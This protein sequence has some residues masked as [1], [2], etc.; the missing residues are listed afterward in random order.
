MSKYSYTLP[1]LIEQS[2]QKFPNK[3][4]FRFMGASISYS[5]LE[6]Q[7]HQLAHLLI[8]LG[9]K[10][11]DRVGI[12][13]A[14][15]LE[16]AIAMYGIMSAGAIYVPINPAQPVARTHFLLKDCGIKYLVTNAGQKRSL[17]SVV[18][19][20]V[21]LESVIGTNVALPTCTIEWSDLAQMPS[22]RPDLSILETDIAYMLYTSGSTGTPKG[23]MHTHYS[24]L[25]YARLSV[26][27]YDLCADDILGNHA[28]IYFD[29][30]T[31]GYFAA[32]LVGATTVIASEAHIKMPAS[33]SQLIEKEKI[34][35][36]Y[37]VPLALIQMLQR[38]ALEQRDMAQLRWVIFAGEL[39][40]TK[41]LRQLMLQWPKARFSNAY[42]PTETNVCTYYHLPAI[43]ENDLPISIG[44]AWNNTEILILGK[45]NRPLRTGQVGE[46][47]VRSATLM[48]GYASRPDLNKKAF[49]FTKNQFGIQKKFYR[50]GDLVKEESDGNLTFLGRKDRQIKTRG[51]RVELDEITTF[52]LQ[53]PN[54]EEAAVY[55]VLNEEEQTLIE[56]AVIL[57]SHEDIKEQDLIQHL[58][59]QLPSYALPHKINI[60]QQFPRTATGK[61]D[62]KLL[63]NN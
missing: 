42:G 20:E 47:L 24:G 37:S 48:E 35:V 1:N 22:H 13:M 55:P 51:F 56:A 14:R 50:T 34:S 52:L 23:I 60:K 12:Y 31:L 17:P 18:T 62:L 29:I 36:W 7:M 10:K 16:T 38:G 11:G 28:P 9:V 6:T 45:D 26:E 33:L 43:P 49:Y 41:H 58:K 57:H 54:V 25:S 3:A 27:A 5:E 32:P 46:L 30:S 19:K 59:N 44:K 8:S 40:P 21:N 2:A 4:A 15:S 39:F 61:I 53:H 63:K